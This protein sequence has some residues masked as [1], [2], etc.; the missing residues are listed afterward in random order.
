MIAKCLLPQA[1]GIERDQERLPNMQ[2]FR[3][4]QDRP[5]NLCPYGGIY[6][7]QAAAIVIVVPAHCLRSTNEAPDTLPSPIPSV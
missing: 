6:R 3:M 4:R 5:A 1:D 7:L 2:I